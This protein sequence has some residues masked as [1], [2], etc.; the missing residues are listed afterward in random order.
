MRVDAPLLLATKTGKANCQ[1]SKTRKARLET[2]RI[3]QEIEMRARQTQVPWPGTNVRRSA[4][5]LVPLEPW[6]CWAR[7]RRRARAGGWRRSGCRGYSRR[8]CWRWCKRSCRTRSR[9][10]C[11]SRS[12][13]CHAAAQPRHGHRIERTTSVGSHFAYYQDEGL[14]IFD[15]K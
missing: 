5:P 1:I 10:R 11:W 13:R 6:R 9:C 7:L 12:W 8:G 3:L 2:F 15:V 4:V 14:A